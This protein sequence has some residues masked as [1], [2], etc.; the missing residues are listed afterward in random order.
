MS[1]SGNDCHYRLQCTGSVRSM[2]IAFLSYLYFFSHFTFSH[3]FSLQDLLSV[4]ALGNYT[5]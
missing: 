3:L 5:F 2:I 4:V 1:I